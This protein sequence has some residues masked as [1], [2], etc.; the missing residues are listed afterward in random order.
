MRPF[1]I[2][3]MLLNMPAMGS[4]TGALV[5]KLSSDAPLNM[6]SNAWLMASKTFPL[7]LV[8]G[9]ALACEAKA[10]AS[11]RTLT[12]FMVRWI[13]PFK[14]QKKLCGKFEELYDRIDEK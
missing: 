5:A 6:L 11:T 8:V 10:T 3:S 7:E 4:E 13:T 1:S 2:L 9:W 14:F 12:R